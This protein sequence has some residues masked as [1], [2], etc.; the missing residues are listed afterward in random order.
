MGGKNLINL[1]FLTIKWQQ[2]IKFCFQS[3]SVSSVQICLHCLRVNLIKTSYSRSYNHTAVPTTTVKSKRGQWS[4]KWGSG[5][6]SSGEI[7]HIFTD[8]GFYLISLIRW[9]IPVIYLLYLI[10]GPS[11]CRIWNKSNHFTNLAVWNSYYI[12]I[13]YSL[14]IERLQWG[15]KL[16]KAQYIYA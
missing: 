1:Q 11:T 12:C 4:H 15:K 9:S 14:E 6:I 2:L 7:S 5:E 16:L 10:N 8:T 3:Q 13:H